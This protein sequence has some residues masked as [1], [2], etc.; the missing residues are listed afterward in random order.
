MYLSFFIPADPVPQERLLEDCF[1]PTQVMLALPVGPPAHAAPRRQPPRFVRGSVIHSIIY[2]PCAA[3]P[4]FSENEKDNVEEDLASLDQEMEESRG[5]KLE[6]RVDVKAKKKL[7]KRELKPDCPPTPPT[8]AVKAKPAAKQSESGRHKKGK[9]IRKASREDEKR[10][11]DLNAIIAIG[12]VVA[13]KREVEK[14]HA[15][16]AQLNADL[17]EERRRRL[18]AEAEQRRTAALLRRVRSLE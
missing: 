11:N 17:D 2:Q 15:K 5:T 18:A 1:S 3:W 10:R 9:K 8:M 7:V 12:S 14:L 16:I 4:W 13:G 6:K